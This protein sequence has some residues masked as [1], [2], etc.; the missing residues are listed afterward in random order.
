MNRWP[1]C[2]ICSFVFHEVILN[3]FRVPCS[4][5]IAGMRFRAGFD[6]VISASTKCT[7]H[8]ESV[9]STSTC[10]WAIHNSVL[11]AAA[12]ITIHS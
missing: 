8:V 10:F 5:C 3:L 6:I 11:I 12:K 4:S 9:H 2:K 1:M 7:I